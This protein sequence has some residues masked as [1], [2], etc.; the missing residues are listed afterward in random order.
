[1]R[2]NLF[3]SPAGEW[4]GAGSGALAP[5]PRPG[6]PSGAA[7]RLW[8]PYKRGDA[9][10]RV[11]SWARFSWPFGPEEGYPGRG[12][13]RGKVPWA[14][15]AAKALPE[16]PARGGLTRTKRL[17]SGQGWL[18]L[19]PDLSGRLFRG[20]H[21]ILSV[22]ELAFAPCMVLLAFMCPGTYAPILASESALRPHAHV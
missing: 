2:V 3:R 15:R 1:M 18:V 17:S 21:K 16:R 4:R 20:R 9:F 10:P 22:L 19:A 5:R 8:R 13:T 7:P 6:G 14:L 11:E 12:G